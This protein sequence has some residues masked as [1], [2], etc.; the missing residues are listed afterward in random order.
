[1]TARGWHSGIPAF[2]HSNDLSRSIIFLN[3]LAA[4]FKIYENLLNTL[5][6]FAD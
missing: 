1:M 4:E 2:R 5:S 3:G 6:S